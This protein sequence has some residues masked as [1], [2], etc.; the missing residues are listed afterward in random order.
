MG[1]EIMTARARLDRSRT[2]RRGGFT[3]VEI[4]VVIAII[5]ALMALTASAVV[6]YIAIQ[7]A[8]NTQSVLDRTQG[9]LA[10]AWSRVKHQ[11]NQETIPAQIESWIRTTLAGTDPNAGQR[12]RYIYVKLALR[13]AFPM[14]F[15]EVFNIGVP[16]A[17]STLMPP[18]PGYTTYLAKLGITP[19][20]IGT[21]PYE[22]QS[23]ACLLMALQRGV[24]GAG[25]DPSE[26]T[27]GGAAGSFSFTNPTT[28]T[29]TNLPYLT[30]NW[31]RPIFFARFPAGSPKLNPAFPGGWPGV[32]DPGDPQGYLISPAWVTSS[33]ATVFHTLTLQPMAPLNQSYKLAP[34]VASGG[35]VNWEKTNLLTFHPFT[36]QPGTYHL[37]T[38][39][40]TASPGTGV[41]YSSP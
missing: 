32:N 39:A 12:V 19:A 11:A 2:A 27:A 15:N 26:L 10:K 1:A 41:M 18:L 36:F 23:S 37:A 9:Q 3:L 16:P 34:M 21:V 5:A 29:P 20:T 35:P 6:K 30:D 38:G 14:N 17:Y 25:I 4:T 7:Q 31:G 8:N 24:S 13:R 28:G 40:F 22:Y 33:Y